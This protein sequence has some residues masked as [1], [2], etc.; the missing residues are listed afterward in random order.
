[1]VLQGKKVLLGVSGG[2]AAYKSAELLRLFVKA[3]AEVDVVMTAH[4]KA[5][6]TPLTLQTLAGRPVLSDTFDL[7]AGAEIKHVSVPDAADL[8]VLAPATANLIGKL[9]H[10]IADDLLTS[11]LL[12]A[13]CP[14]LVAP[15]MNVSMWSHPIVRANLATLVD[16]LG[17]HVVE[18]VEGM[19]AC[20]YEG[21]GKL[22]DPQDIFAAA[23]KLF[24]AP[25]LKG[26]KV[27]VTAGPTR[28]YLDP[29]RFIS[30]PSTGKMGAAVAEAAAA[31]GAAVTLVLGP[32]ALS[33]HPAVRVVR[34]ESADEMY[35]AAKAAYA[36]CDV[37]VA[38]AA[39]ADYK[40][41]ERAPH[42]VK[43]GAEPATVKL[44][45]TPDILLELSKKKGPRVLVGFAA[46]TTDV[47]AH[48]TEKLRKKNCD[49]V[50]A[51]DVTAPGSGFGT[52]TN[53]VLLVDGEGAQALPLLGK[54]EV[55]HRILDRV[56]GL[57]EQ[58]RGVK[59]AKRRDA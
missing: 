17:Y 9:A 37:F 47:I 56:A 46:E 1:M 43:K 55:A 19:L 12:V 31:R 15:A 18:P 57:L 16:T 10:G 3:G 5:F 28:E 41:A 13:R 59:R 30:N 20:G 7:S 58:R 24:A 35:A 51:N 42:K 27:L 38:A 2:I 29:V 40:P 45:R 48:A 14:V 34:V 6:I 54:G 11:M 26:K 21:K 39:V 50:V 33:V 23:E 8:V 4:A 32:V 25:D 52:D 44:V 53:R 36:A 49:F 22:A